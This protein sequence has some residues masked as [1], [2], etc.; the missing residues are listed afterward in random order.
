MDKYRIHTRYGFAPEYNEYKFNNSKNSSE[1]ISSLALGD[2]I[3][4]SI[5]NSLSRWSIEYHIY[6]SVEEAEIAAVER[7]EI[8]SIYLKNSIDYPLA[9]YSVG[10]NCWHLLQVGAIIYIRNNILVL[11]TPE[12]NVVNFDSTEV[13][14][15][16]YSIDSILLNKK[17]I[18][19]FS[20]IGAPTVESSELISEPPFEI[21]DRIEFKIMIKD[22]SKQNNYFRING[23]GLSSISK[24]G[25]FN[26]KIN[27]YILFEKDNK[28]YIRTWI[29]ND[30]LKTTSALVEIPL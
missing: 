10:D 15:I 24:D 4:G 9:E 1:L 7:M 20:L 30:D 5:D 14:Q 29:W 3:G 23:T 8:S 22:D 13:K 27:D 16:A 26:I 6:T 2:L 18:T 19:D 12:L 17:K 11:L 25:Y 21:N 28:K